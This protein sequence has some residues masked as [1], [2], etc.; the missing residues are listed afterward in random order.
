MIQDLQQRQTALKAESSFIVQAPAGSG[1]TGLLV[2][3]MLVL[4]ARV[5]RPENVLAITFTRKA[6][7]EMRQRLLELLKMAEARQTSSDEF[8]QQGIELAHQVLK[9]DQL[10]NWQLLNTPYQLQIL[11]IDAFCG[12]LTGHMPWLSRL[13]DKPRTTDNAELHYAA[14]V[15]QLFNEL[16]GE[17]SELSDDL[18]TV[19]LELDFNY[20]RARKLFNAMLG[21]RDQWLRHLLQHDLREMREQIQL[22]W[23]GIRDQH[24]AKLEESL[25]LATQQ[26]LCEL[27]IKASSLI[28][29]TEQE[30]SQLACFESYQLGSALSLRH[31]QALKFL[32]LTNIGGLRKRLTKKE[33]FPP[34]EKDHKKSMQAILDEL[35]DDV[36]FIQCL[37][38]VDFLPDEQFAEADWQ[39]LLALENVLKSLAAFLQ[40]RFRASGECDHS[41]VT[42]R[43]NLAMQELANP[44]DLALRLDY[45]IRH[46]LV[47]EFQDTS[48]AQLQLLKKLTAGWELNDQSRTL[49]LVG[50]P[51]QSIYRFREADVGLFL[52]VVK[53]DSSRVFENIDIQS[54]QL[55]ENF[56]SSLSLVDW[57]NTTFSDSFPAVDQVL[58]GAISYA[59]STCSRDDEGRSVVVTQLAEDKKGEAQL[60]VKAIQRSLEELNSDYDCN[61]NKKIAVLV[62]S[63]S[64]LRALLPAIQQADIAYE[65]V[66]I[67][68]LQ[69]AQ[70]VIDVL[71]LCKAINHLDDRIAWL[72]LLRGPW[73]GLSLIQI[74]AA[75]SRT[76]RTVWDQVT[77][78]DTS[79][80]DAETQQRLSR[81]CDVM[82]HALKHRQQFGLH[83]ITRWAWQSLGGQ[84]TLFGLSVDD[85]ESVFELIERCQRGGNL[86]SINELERSLEGLYAQPPKNTNA[87]VVISTMHKAKGLQYDTVILPCLTNLPRAEQKDILMWAEHQSDLG[88]AQLL[89]API[90]SG[91]ASDNNHYEYL[92][93]LERRRSGN[94]A[95]RLLYVAC[96]RAERKL[97]LIARANIDQKTEEIKT[98]DSRTL[99]ATV[100]DAL[101]NRFEL[102]ANHLTENHEEDDKGN[103]VALDQTL[104]RLPGDF[105]VTFGEPINWQ[106]RHQLQS[107]FNAQDFAQKNDF[108]WATEVATAVGMVMHEWLQ[109]N[110]PSLFKSDLN[111]DQLTAWRAQWKAQ[112]Q[113]LNV[114][115]DRVGFAL[116]RL[117]KG[118]DNMRNDNRAEFIFSDYEV[119]KNEFEIAAFE[120]GLVNHYRIDR[121]FVDQD[122]IR[123]IV[124]Y[125]TTVTRAEDIDQFIDQQ[126]AE[127]HRVQLEKYGSLMS[128]IDSR[129]IKLA[130]YFPMLA[131]LRSWDYQT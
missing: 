68:P 35:V 69:E 40:L 119:Q 131:K 12:K 121:T 44:T 101:Q 9:Q 50:D 11:T 93:Q 5:E 88:E 125:K 89:L 85:V 2:Y 24:L 124:D 54:L 108:E 22:S 37:K 87:R 77:K 51:M 78:L 100:W 13:G 59:H 46:I 118:V 70:A 91:G 60:V 76:D 36:D 130:V 64:H 6:T 66:D 71:A 117:Q 127:R 41:E 113:S 31:W 53:N 75:V 42:Q 65:G 99:L 105:N 115:S 47:D 104:A 45:Q 49:F 123:W 32:L 20:A 15:E 96:T 97:V 98:P 3:R 90:H 56:R 120:N 52:Q 92:R 48:H 16:L 111:D 39:Q 28:A 128:E 8:E 107:Q 43:A 79:C 58:N 109:F 23:R 18:Q 67:L 110:Q 112:L 26:R 103:E 7:S 55:T 4:L 73:C 63:R 38:E 114:P 27:A 10:H 1:K 81:F 83:S 21:R 33:G 94:E 74:K 14:A 25:P 95:V 82:Q 29:V 17:S 129:Q 61:N 106:S 116:D 19:L 34:A 80:F 72:A 84:E 122:N 102:Q 126:V 57:F 62:R 30:S 86:I